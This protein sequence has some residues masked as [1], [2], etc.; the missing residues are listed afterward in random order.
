MGLTL[1][2]VCSHLHCDIPVVQ[3]P[4]PLLPLLPLLLSPHTQSLAVDIQY[5]IHVQCHA[6]EIMDSVLILM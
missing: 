6:L 2:C 3:Y 5:T 4:P 1:V